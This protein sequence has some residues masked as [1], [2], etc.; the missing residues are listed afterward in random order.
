MII[1]GKNRNNSLTFTSSS[2]ASMEYPHH[3]YFHIIKGF[4]SEEHGV[5]PSSMDRTKVTSGVKLAKITA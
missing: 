5:Y 2:G 3:T 4:M 1:R